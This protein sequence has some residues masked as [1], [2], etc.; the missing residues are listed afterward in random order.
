MK[1]HAQTLHHQLALAVFDFCMGLREVFIKIIL[2]PFGKGV[3]SLK[4]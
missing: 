4:P 1:F 3:A 2:L